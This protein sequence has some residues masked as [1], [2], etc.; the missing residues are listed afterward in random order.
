MPQIA[1]LTGTGRALQGSEMTPLPEVY[2]L[3][4]PAEEETGW[5]D[6]ILQLPNPHDATRNRDKPY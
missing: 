4:V 6:Q 3:K 2:G 1:K 5:V